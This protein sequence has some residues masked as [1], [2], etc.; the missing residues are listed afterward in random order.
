MVTTD[1]ETL[2][3]IKAAETKNGEN[4][5]NLL[6]EIN[7]LKVL[8]KNLQEK[9]SVSETNLKNYQTVREVEGK[10]ILYE[11]NEEKIHIDSLE[12]EI[13]NLKLLNS[14]CEKKMKFEIDKI[15][16]DSLAEKKEIELL[17]N[18]E[19]KEQFEKN[20]MESDRILIDITKDHF[21]ILVKERKIFEEAISLAREE[22]ETA[23]SRVNSN[24]SSEGQAVLSLQTQ[25]GS[26]KQQI[27]R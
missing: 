23:V 16:S 7:N 2:K 12:K 9:L 5:N 27:N 15:E 26:L 19:L 25:L 18:A 4:E 8:I 17:H 13:I 21:D 1:L 6:T 10:N 24:N 20:K 14:E 22:L 3:S 11:K